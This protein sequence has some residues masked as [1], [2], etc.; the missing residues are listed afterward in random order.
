MCKTI[1][2]CQTQRCLLDN[3]LVGK[4]YIGVI[5]AP[6]FATRCECV[7]VHVLI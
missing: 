6:E 5:Y 4:S 7:R 3:N 2:H 1:S